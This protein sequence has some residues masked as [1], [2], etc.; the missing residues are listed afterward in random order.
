MLEEQ[1]LDEFAARLHSETQDKV[2]E[3]EPEMP[4]ALD[5]A[6]AEIMLGYLEEAGVVADHE[7]CP[8]EDS[9]GQGRCRIIGYSLPE[10]STRL[11][12]FT[13]QYVESAVKCYKDL[14]SVGVKDLSR[15]ISRLR[16]RQFGI[17]VT[18]SHVAI[19]A[20]QE[21]KEDRHP[22]V[23]IVANDIVR[24]LKA[25]GVSNTANIATWLSAF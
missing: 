24:I 22:I 6:V 14:N 17:L 7:V 19:Q 15:L 9:A 18:T 1:L 25:A 20:Y 4:L 13:S 10:G 12:L 21:I 5:A 2:S 11:E 16:H 8:Y 23:I 3:F